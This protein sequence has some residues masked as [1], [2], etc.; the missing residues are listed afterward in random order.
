LDHENNYEQASSILQGLT[1]RNH[2]D[3]RYVL[4]YTR[5]KMFDGLFKGDNS[6]ILSFHQEW[7]SYLKSLGDNKDTFVHV[8]RDIINY[9]LMPYYIVSNKYIE[10]D[11][12]IEYID[13]KWLYEDVFIQPVYDFYLRRGLSDKAYDYINGAYN[14]LTSA[15]KPISSFIVSIISNPNNPELI[16]KRQQ[17][18]TII[19]THYKNIPVI[20]PENINAKRELNYFLLNELIQALHQ[21]RE[22]INAVSKLKTED[23]YTDILQS[24]LS[25]RFSFYGW[26]I[27]NNSHFGL[28]ETGKGPGEP[29]LI[30]KSNNQTIAIA[31]AFKLEGKNSD[32]IKTHILKCFNYSI[33]LDRY[34]IIIYY[35]G[36]PENIHKTWE[37][38]MEVFKAINFP[39]DSKPIEASNI[40]TQINNEFDNSRNIIISSTSHIGNFKMY[41]IMVNFNKD[42]T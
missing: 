14:Y 26:N 30:I 32:V 36:K 38:Y 7:E 34:F 11:Y 16:K 20:I 10:F 24:I 19:T 29:D 12:A 21:M 40:F 17:F 6:L 18:E 31:E 4:S 37:S 27:Q 42:I 41:H 3:M 35:I 28:S 23:D 2:Q 15:E 5:A 22:K 1:E 8:N 25:L 13:K 9:C 33:T 39:N